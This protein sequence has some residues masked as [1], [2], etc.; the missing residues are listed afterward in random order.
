MR[1]A[2]ETAFALSTE[3]KSGIYA[4]ERADMP[5]LPDIELA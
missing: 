1:P 2:G 4:H 3:A 5:D